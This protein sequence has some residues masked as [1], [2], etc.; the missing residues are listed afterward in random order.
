MFSTLIGDKI[1]FFYILILLNWGLKQLTNK[2]WLI[3]IVVSDSKY[4]DLFCH[5][6]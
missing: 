3:E 4:K 5:C 6:K 2:F 1:L